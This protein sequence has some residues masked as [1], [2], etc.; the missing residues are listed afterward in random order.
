MCE[1]IG[2]RKLSPY[3]PAPT[4]RA[5]AIKRTALLGSGLTEQHPDHGCNQPNETSHRY[6]DETALDGVH[7]PSPCRPIVPEQPQ[8]VTY[9]GELARLSRDEA[10]C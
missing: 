9:I 2:D 4:N 8:A 7:H 5:G 1:A 10:T 3:Q 6:C